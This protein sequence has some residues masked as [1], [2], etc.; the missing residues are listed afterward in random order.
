MARHR[1]SKRRRSSIEDKLFWGL[2]D[3]GGA[4][5]LGE[6]FTWAAFDEH[7]PGR[8]TPPGPEVPSAVAS[9]LLRMYRDG[10]VWFEGMKDTAE[11]A[12]ELPK[13]ASTVRWLPDENRYSAGDES[14]RTVCVHLTQKAYDAYDMAR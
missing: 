6:L 5:D 11:L 10:I 12:E 3:W 13:M 2:D 9:T 7:V 4:A 14:L 8:T 1:T